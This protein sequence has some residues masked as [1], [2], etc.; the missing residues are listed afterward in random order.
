MRIFKMPYETELNI[1]ILGGIIDIYQAVCMGVVLIIVTPTLLSMTWL[2]LVLRIAGII[3]AAIAG[4]IFAV[5]RVGD[6][7]FIQYIY[8]RSRFFGNAGKIQYPN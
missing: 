6:L 2:P 5:V 4:V 1:K 7:N 8:Y 3:L